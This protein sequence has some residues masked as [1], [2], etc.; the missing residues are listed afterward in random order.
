VQEAFRT[1]LRMGAAGP[2]A[3]TATLSRLLLARWEALWTFAYR[4]GVEPTN[5]RAERAL[6]PAI[7]TTQP[8]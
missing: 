2:C 5:N 6:R 7:L 3:K 8:A 4:E 1:L